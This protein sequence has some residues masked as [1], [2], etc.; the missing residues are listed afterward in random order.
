MRRLKE[1][2]TVGVTMPVSFSGYVLRPRKKTLPW[3]ES[4]YGL[5]NRN[6][7]TIFIEKAHRG[8]IDGYKRHQKA[9]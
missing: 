2:V 8:L 4:R 9:D 7:Q 1:K 5:R 3:D 6:R